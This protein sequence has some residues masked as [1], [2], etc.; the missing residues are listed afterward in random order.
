MEGTGIRPGLIG[1]VGC[2][3]PVEPV[4][5]KVLRASALAGRETGAAVSIHPGRDPRA[6][7][8]IVEVLGACGAALG[9]TVMCRVD[10]TLAD[11][12]ALRRL[13]ATGIVIEFDVF[14]HEGSH[15]AWELPLDMPKDSRRVRLLRWLADKVFADALGVFHDVYFKDKLARWGGQG[16]SHI[17]ENVVPLMRRLGWP[18][19]SSAPCWSTRRAGC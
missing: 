11:R 14:G 18:G 17:V 1:E 3:W 9:R 19:R 6:P 16:C 4:E 10:R 7:F 12:A 8:E 13:A 5:R 15:Y 2:S